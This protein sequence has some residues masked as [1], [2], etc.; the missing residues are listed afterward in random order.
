MKHIALFASGRGSTMQ[1]VLDACR[2]G[3]LTAEPV[4]MVTSDMV[5]SAANRAREAGLPLVYS[6]Q[7]SC[8]ML[9]RYQADW[10][11]LC[12]YLCQL[13]AEVVERY[14]G[15][16]VNVH[17][18]LL[19][20]YGGRGYYGANV[21]RAVLEA[22]DVITGATV[23][24]VDEGLDTGPILAQSAIPVVDGDTPSLLAERLRPIEHAL[25]VETLRK[26]IG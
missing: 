6:R 24:M 14:R 1:A 11:I 3:R 23:H 13:G 10:L 16:I 19:P 15:R 17:P 18:S 7:P 25:Y 22:G 9:E 20:K 5:S 21:H 8:D 2:D 12:G 4:I 26:I